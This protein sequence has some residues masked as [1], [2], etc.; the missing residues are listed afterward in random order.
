MILPALMSLLGDK[1]W[2]P[3]RAVLRAR[4]AAPRSR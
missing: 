1:S 4:A 3:S 2:W